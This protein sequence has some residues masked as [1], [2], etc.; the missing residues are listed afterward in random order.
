MNTVSEVSARLYTEGEKDPVVRLLVAN[1]VAESDVF[2]KM[3]RSLTKSMMGSAFYIASDVN[4]RLGIINCFTCSYEPVGGG[5]LNGSVML[6]GSITML[7]QPEF[8]VK[9]AMEE[10]VEITTRLVNFDGEYTL[11]ASTEEDHW[12]KQFII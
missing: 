2:Y 8:L 5:N 4:R 11:S 3:V 10:E 1:V 7:L 12:W 9:Y 6:N